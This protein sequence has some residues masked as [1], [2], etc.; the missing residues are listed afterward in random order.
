MKT[1]HSAIRTPVSAALR[2]S[3][4]CAIALFLQGAT[5]L[6]VGVAISGNLANFDVRYPTSLPNDLEVVIYGDF[7][8]PTP[9]NPAPCVIGTWNTNNLLGGLGV[10]WGQASS[11]TQTV[12][13]DPTSPGFGLDCIVIRWA[14][15]PRPAM[16]NQ[17]VHFG[18][19]LRPGCAVHHQEVWWTINGTRINRPCDPHIT[20]ICT[21]TGWVI[22]IGNPT[23]FPIY[24][25][26]CRHFT[27]ATTATLPNLN[28]LNFGINPAQFGAPGWTPVQIPGGGPV[29]CLQ[30]WCRIYIRVVVTTWRPPIFQIA[31]RNVANEQFPLQPAPDGGPNPNDFNGE[32]GTMMIMTTRPTQEFAEDI[33]GDAVVGIPDFNMWRTR[34][35]AVSQ[36][37]TPPPTTP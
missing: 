25:Y 17:M 29:L 36:D 2:W 23:P 10:Q 9:T 32:M 14:G 33:N 15:P 3:A 28:Q 22:C 19:H 31:V 21:R 34:N 11:I 1:I 30:P 7:L 13:T 18:V 5:A 24:V 12:N 6:G 27:P 4:I 26:G 35:G 8:P 37:L 16:V 20:W